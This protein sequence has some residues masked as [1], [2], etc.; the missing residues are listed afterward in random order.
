VFVTHGLTR[1]LV[2]T[3]ATIDDELAAI[4]DGADNSQDAV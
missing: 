2:R 1:P 4:T 3:A